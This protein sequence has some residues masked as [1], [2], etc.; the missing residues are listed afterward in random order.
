MTE[1]LVQGK[2][3]AGNP[4]IWFDDVE[5]DLTATPR[6]LSMRCETKTRLEVCLGLLFC[7]VCPMLAAA[8]VAGAACALSSG[9][10]G[11][12]APVEDAREMVRT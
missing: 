1:K 4:H 3:Y 2:P 12:R 11:F 9:V 10:A 6:R 7:L 5:V 8:A